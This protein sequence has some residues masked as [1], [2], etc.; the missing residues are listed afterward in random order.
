MVN[1]IQEYRP[2]GVAVTDLSAQLWC[3]KQLEFS[4]E[5]GRIETEEMSKGKE[6]HKN[7]HEEVAILITVEPKTQADRI[8]LKIHNAQ[9]GLKRLINERMTRELSIFGRINSLFILGSI[10]ELQKRGKSL[11]ILD[12]KTRK[13]NTLP[14]EAQKR[15]TKF[16][17]MLYHKLIS[18]IIS[19]KFQTDDIMK[20]YN[21][22]DSD[23]ISNEFK[24][25]IRE[26]GQT[27]EPNIKRLIDTTFSLFKK[28]PLPEKTM[29]IRYEYQETKELIGIDEFSFDA[30]NFERDCN[31]VE[32]FWSG[33]RKAIPVGINNAWK[34]KWCEFYNICDQKPVQ[35]RN[36]ATQLKLNQ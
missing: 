19:G 17:L 36:Q 7:L 24:K 29:Q 26:I 15:T 28:L 22:G 9:V 12:T 25:Q 23:K 21:F 32:G 18:D 4:L 13:N 27:I 6:R 1:L 33:K 14:S 31:F 2:Y 5:K 30:L 8:A 20:V 16:Q 35:Q 11:F 3:E 34:C 10:D